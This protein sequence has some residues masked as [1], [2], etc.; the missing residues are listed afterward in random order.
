MKARTLLVLPG[1]LL[2]LPAPAVAQGAIIE[3]LDDLPAIPMAEVHRGALPATI[4]LSSRLP[5]PRDQGRTKTWAHQDMYVVVGNLCRCLRGAA[6]R[7][8][9]PAGPPA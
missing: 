3:R 8:R 1:L 7:F 9:G 6:A 5:P 2:G 4:D